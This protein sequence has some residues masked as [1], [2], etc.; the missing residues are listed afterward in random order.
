VW[1]RAAM[2]GGLGGRSSRREVLEDRREK[3]PKTST[4]SSENCCE[5]GE[6]RKRK[7]VVQEVCESGM[8]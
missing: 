3:R 5:G 1:N 2:D 4:K 8:A 6:Y 7:F